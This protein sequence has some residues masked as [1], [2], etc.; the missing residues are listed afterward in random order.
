[1]ARVDRAGNKE[2]RLL[3]KNRPQLAAA[4]KR[5]EED[6][7]SDVIIDLGEDAGEMRL[8]LILRNM[9]RHD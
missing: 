6:E 3:K 8:T 2:N 4:S 1:M 7:P 9:I 5:Y